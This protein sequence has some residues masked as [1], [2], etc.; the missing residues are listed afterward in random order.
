MDSPTPG[1]LRTSTGPHAGAPNAL[2]DEQVDTLYATTDPIAKHVRKLGGATL[3]SIG[4]SR[5]LRRPPTTTRP[6]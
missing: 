1:A 5:G 3:R 6:T 2:L 4:T